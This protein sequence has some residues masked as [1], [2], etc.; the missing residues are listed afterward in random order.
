MLYRLIEYM[1]PQWQKNKNIEKDIFQEHKKFTGM[2][3]IQAKYRYLQVVKSL[4]TYGITFFEV[5]EKL[6]GKNKLVKILLGITRDKII[7]ADFETKEPMREWELTQ[8][9]RWAAGANSFTLDFGD[10]EEDYIVILTNEGEAISRLLGDYIDLIL[11]ARKGMLGLLVCRT[12]LPNNV[13][14]MLLVS[15]LKTT[16]KLLKKKSSLTKEAMPISQ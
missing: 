3:D 6:R 7:K 5:R 13:L 14:Q 9:R 15:K 11:K 12:T 10:Y 2:T 4:K 1:A 8:M 16:L